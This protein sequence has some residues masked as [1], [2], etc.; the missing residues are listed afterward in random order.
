MRMLWAA[1]ALAGAIAWTAGAQAA[2]FD[3]RKASTAAERLICAQPALSRLDEELALAF[4][5]AMA[6]TPTPASLA[7]E[8]RAGLKER[9]RNA[10]ARAM[11]EAYRFRLEAL[12]LHRTVH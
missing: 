12:G 5:D 9:D 8:Q 1:V 7:R 11:E 4:K 6:I 3:C 2:S 10:D